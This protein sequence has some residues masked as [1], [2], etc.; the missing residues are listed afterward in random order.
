MEPVTG[1]HS[2]V[3]DSLQ[4]IEEHIISKFPAVVIDTEGV[5]YPVEFINPRPA[6]VELQKIVGGLIQFVDLPD[7]C[8]AHKT[9]V[10][11]EEG[12]L[13]G[14]P[15]NRR[16]TRIANGNVAIFEGDSIVGNILI[17]DRALLEDEEEEDDLQ[18][19]TT[20]PPQP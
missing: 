4:T 19:D 10:I 9:M 16:G 12:K 3:T 2:C 5:A 13:C 14:L 20:T 6:L 18:G 11:N 17:V 8:G 7:Y 1:A 15:L